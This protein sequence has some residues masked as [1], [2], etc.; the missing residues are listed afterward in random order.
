[1]FAPPPLFAAQA[2]EEHASTPEPKRRRLD[3]T[4]EEN[5]DPN[6][7]SS[8]VKAP[9]PSS[10]NAL[11]GCASV[12]TGNAPAAGSLNAEQLERIQQKRLEA[13][14]RKQQKS[15]IQDLD[16]EKRARIEQNRLA[17]LARKQQRA[18][19]DERRAEPGNETSSE[20][21]L[22]MEKR[23]RIEQNR[24]AA[25][26][27]KQQRT[28]ATQ[29]AESVSNELDCGASHERLQTS[30]AEEV[31]DAESSAT[32]P[33][34][35]LSFS[36]PSTPSSESLMGTTDSDDEQYNS[37]LSDNSP[38]SSESGSCESSSSSSDGTSSSSSSESE[39]EEVPQ[40]KSGLTAEQ[41]AKIAQN[42]RAALARKRGLSSEQ[43][44]RIEENRRA[45]L[46]RKRGLKPDE[47]ARIE[48]NRR[49]ALERKKNRQAVE[50]EMPSKEEKEDE[51]EV[52][53]IAAVKAGVPPP[54]PTEERDA[55]QRLVAQLLCR[56]WWA[57]PPWP[58]ENFDCDAEL[59]RLRFRRVSTLTFDREPELD[60]KGFRKAYELEQFRGCF[61]T[62]SGELL[63]VRPKEGRPSYDQ[64]MLKTT[65]DLY[66][67]LIAA[68]DGQLMELF[69]ESQKKG[70]S[71]ELEQHLQDLRKQAAQVRQKATFYL[72]AK[73]SK[74]PAAKKP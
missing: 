71:K 52:Q 59:T 40:A 45:A 21:G 50:V 65:P 6:L 48:E 10:C 33:T 4:T 3:S 20:Q 1:M 38:S 29:E 36:A 68:F 66:R 26:A 70:A 72:W 57:M 24:L 47:L 67:L 35:S 62:S 15:C 53:W 31:N 23:N 49:K 69:T 58:P 42:R 73:P 27:R 39:T 37:S 30:A 43:L 2:F 25:L 34:P 9:E 44:A 5:A 63:D 64:L 13:L 18:C 11:A 16:L 55:R 8:D 60:E 19:L 56:W 54:K 28:A 51:A 74:S 14:Q 17:A 41:L 22:D 61:R 32:P 12:P 46:A 7:G